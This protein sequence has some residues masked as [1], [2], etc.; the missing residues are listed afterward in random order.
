MDIVGFHKSDSHGI[1][2]DDSANL[3]ECS[4]THV[5]AD[6]GLLLKEVL[7]KVLQDDTSLAAHYLLS[8]VEKNYL[9]H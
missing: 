9:V 3:T 6:S 2:G 1:C 8:F 7:F 5:Q 4:R